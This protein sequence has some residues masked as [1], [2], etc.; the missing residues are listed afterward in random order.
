MY[1]F[2]INFIR[3]FYRF[4]ILIILIFMGACSPNNQQIPPAQTEN[5]VIP[6]EALI[7]HIEVMIFESFPVH[8]NVVAKGN[9]PD[10]CTTINQITEEQSG[11]TLM[12]KITTDRL[13][14]KV[15]TKGEKIFEEVIPLNVA[16]LK[17]GIYTV[18]VNQIT[19]FFELGIDNIIP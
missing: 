9:L 18:K 8:I 3:D 6:T 17:A 12:V 15:C 2:I 11:N 1:F 7:E 14:D 4:I 13:T 19:N 16:G 5:A 10:N